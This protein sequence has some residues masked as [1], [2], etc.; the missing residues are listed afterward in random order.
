MIP[1]WRPTSTTWA[2]VAGPGRSAGRQGGLRAGAR[3]DEKASARTTPTSPAEST[4]WAW[5]CETWAIW[6]APGR[7]SSGRSRSTRK[8]SAPTTPMSPHGVNNLGSVLQA[9]GDLAGARAA[10]ERA[11][12]IDEKILGPTTPRSPS[13]STT[14]A[15]CCEPRAIWRAPGRPSSGRSRSTKHLRPRPPRGRHGRQQPGRGAASPGRSGGRQGGL[16]AGAAIFERS[17]RPDH[18]NIATCAVT[19]TAW[20]G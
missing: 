5:C 7:P 10:F 4:T 14:W 9:L 16:R 17:P 15:R 11:L 18:P 19:W 20:A 2:C 13:T 3:I 8:A 12:Q 1:K 6:R